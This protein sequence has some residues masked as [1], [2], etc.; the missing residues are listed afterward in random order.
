MPAMVRGQLSEGY[1]VAA[2]QVC[3][4]LMVG[5]VVKGRTDLVIPV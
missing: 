4:Q 3:D 2:C 5:M 1:H